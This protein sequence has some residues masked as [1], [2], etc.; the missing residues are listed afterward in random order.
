MIELGSKVCDKITGFEGI[1][2]ARI[3]YLHGTDR[4]C[5]ERLSVDDGRTME[6]WLEAPRLTVLARLTVLE[7]D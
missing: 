1:V 3:H 4:Y 7:S 6:A 5:V 2:T